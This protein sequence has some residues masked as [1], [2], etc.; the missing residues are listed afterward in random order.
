VNS[1]QKGFTLIELMIVIAIIGILAAIAIPAYK[2]YTVRARVVEGI[3]MA[4][5]AKLAV[6]E[7]TTTNNTVPA[8][9]AAT[10]Y[11]SPES[12]ENVA[13]ITIGDGNGAII[14]TYTPV[15]GGGTI[16]LKP[17]LKE[18]GDIVWDCKGGTELAKYRPS[19]CRS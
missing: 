5:S 13:S 7:T 6:S 3:E 12:T 10:G 16:I 14:I 9:Q 4:A 2:D 15:A 18:N 19:N 11:V 17:T 8:N 1:K